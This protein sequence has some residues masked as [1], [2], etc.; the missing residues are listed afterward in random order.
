[1][2]ATLAPE[3]ATSC[4]PAAPRHKNSRINTSAARQPHPQPRKKKRAGGACEIKT[5]GEQFKSPNMHESRWC[6]TKGAHGAFTDDKN[7]DGMGGN[8][9]LAPKVGHKREL[10]EITKAFAAFLDDFIGRLRQV[11]LPP[12]LAPNN[13]CSREAIAM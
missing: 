7:A 13:I 5:G 11:E 6:E 8:F 2:R 1:M 12:R 3:P 4:P 9:V 10:V